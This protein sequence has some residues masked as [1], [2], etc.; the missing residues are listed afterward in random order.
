MALRR[1]GKPVWLLN[2]NDEAHGLTQYKNKKDWT[3]RMQQF[4]DHYLPGAL[5]PVW[6]KE[7]VP[8]VEK[9]K[10]LGTETTSSE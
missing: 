9:G 3:V 6:L 7:G 2:Y 8:A 1:L 10:T 5:A 4:F